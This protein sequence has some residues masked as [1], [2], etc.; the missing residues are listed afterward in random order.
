MRNKQEINLTP[1]RVASMALHMQLGDIAE[2]FNLTIGDVERMLEL[3]GVKTGG[4]VVVHCNRSYRR[5]VC[6]GW[7]AAY[8]RV[9]ILGRVDWEWWSARPEDLA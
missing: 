8:L 7:R 1:A 5:W 9:C 3:A 2:R 6:R 4:R